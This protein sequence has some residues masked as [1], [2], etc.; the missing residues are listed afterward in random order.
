MTNKIYLPLLLVSAL[1]IHVAPSWA[2]NDVMEKRFSFRHYLNAGSPVGVSS[3]KNGLAF[4]APPGTDL[5]QLTLA[6]ESAAVVTSSKQSIWLQLAGPVELKSKQGLFFVEFKEELPISALAAVAIQ[7]ELQPEIQTV[8]PVLSRMTG[9]A[10]YD[11]HLAVTAKPG[12]LDSVLAQV[13]HKTG[14]ELVRYSVIPNTAL[15]QVGDLFHRDAVDAS[16]ALRGLPG[17]VSADPVLYRELKTLATVNDPEHSRQWHLYRSLSMDVPG[18]GQIFAHDAWSLTKGDPQVVVAVFD[19][20]TDISHEDLSP[21]IVGGLDAVDGDD[22]P[23]PECSPSQD[24]NSEA[25]SCPNWAP[26]RESHGTSVS[27]TIAA[28]GDNNIGLAGVCPLCSL[29]PVR[30]LGS[31]AESG[32]STAEAFVMAVDDGAWVINNS[33]G[34]GASVFFPLGGPINTAFEYAATQ[35]RD[36][37]G[38][39]IFFAAGNDTTDV[40]VNGYANSKWTVAVAA[41][42]NLDDF[43]VYSNYGDEIDMAAPSRGGAVNQDDYG[44]ATTDVPG[45]EGYSDGDY[46]YGFGGTS[47]ASPVASGIAGLILSRNPELTADQV[48]VIMTSTADKI[49]A[50][51]VNWEQVFGQSLEEVFAY[52]ETGHSIGFGW[53]RLN[54]GKAVAIAL[55]FGIMGSA[56]SHDNQCAVCNQ[57]ERCEVECDEQSDCPDGTR[58]GENNSCEMPAPKVT[59]VGQPCHSDCASCVVA[60]DTDFAET[61]I[62]TDIC[63]VDSDCPQGFDCRLLDAQGDRVCAVGSSAAGD[64]LQFWNCQ[65]PWYGSS[66]VVQGEDEQAYCADSCFAE[67]DGACPYGFHCSASICECEVESPWGCFQYLC[68]EDRFDRNE[69]FGPMC[70][71]D[72]GFGVECQID[73]DC[74]LGDYCS[75]EGACRVDDRNGCSTCNVCETRE[76][77]GPNARCFIP[78]DQD[79]GSCTRRCDD[80]ADCSGDS[81]CAPVDTRFGPV[82]MCSDPNASDDPSVLCTESYVCEVECREDVPCGSNELCEQGECVPTPEGYCDES[83]F[84]T[85]GEECIENTCTLIEVKAPDLNPED[86]ET[87]FGA[88]GIDMENCA[89]RS[90]SGSS[91]IWLLGLLGALRLFRRKIYNIGAT[92]RTTRLS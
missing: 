30:M 22:D 83:H 34:P 54:A 33:W 45:D 26:Y 82:P 72:A 25:S 19:S 11:E 92:S 47:A 17:L 69:G 27:G 85:A 57:N 5:S 24:G 50:D 80:D 63:E 3:L 14:G 40:G 53:G 37:K 59:K 9:R 8:Y 39:L 2:A 49:T 79:S 60:I 16:A 78:E 55:D 29:Y 81:V 12:Q 88:L 77:C 70:F 64:P 62:C 61:T 28:R 91:P 52:D 18:D 43:A 41:S 74:K 32:F 56:C 67:G 76:D 21:N 75:A 7:L 58:C 71:P 84:C 90:T 48:R 89:C 15:V 46:N 87:D 23:S 42:T 65:S 38:T 10:F 51:K 1:A 66:I 68:T 13:I 4:R 36:G 86:G 44:I 31:G 35:G 73:D 6:V 20:G